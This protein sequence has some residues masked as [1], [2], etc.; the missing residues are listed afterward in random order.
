MRIFLLTVLF[1]VIGSAA[2]SAE[3]CENFAKYAAIRAYKA[4]VGTVQGS[5][6]IDY[7]A[8]L[9]AKEQSRLLFVVSISDNNEDGETWTTD[10]QVEILRE[11]GAC[12]IRSV[13]EVVP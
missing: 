12:K 13:R 11:K 9:V 2:F 3:L 1:S 4:S 10:Y 5:E 8:K 7:A 6:G